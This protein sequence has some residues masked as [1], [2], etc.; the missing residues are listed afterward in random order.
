MMRWRG[1]IIINIMDQRPKRTRRRRNNKPAQNQVAIVQQPNNERRT[2]GRKAMGKYIAPANSLM[3]QAPGVSNAPRLRATRIKE[4]M[5]Q[6]PLTKD[7]SSFLKC[8]FAPPD[9]DATVLLGV[10]DEYQGRSLV[11]RHRLVQSVAYIA[12]STDYYYLLLPVP[13]YAYFVASVAAGT[14]ITSSTTFTGVPYS[15]SFPG[16]FGSSTTM[17]DN[18]N[19]FRFVSNHIEFVP[20]TNA[21]SWT[22]N[23][24]CFKAPINVF[25][26]QN[27]IA[28]AT[29]LYSVGG[30]Q[31]VNS[32]NVNQYTGPFNLGV[33]SGAYNNGS[34]F[35]FSPIFENAQ[36]IP[37]QWNASFG[38]WGILAVPTVPANA[39][40][41]TGFDNNFESVVIKVTGM[42]TNVSNTAIIKTWA[43]VE[44]QC[45]DSGVLYEYQNFSPC[46]PNALAL[47]RKIINE[48]PPGVAFTDNENFWR[49]VLEIIRRIS[50]AGAILPGPY[51]MASKGVNMLS[52]AISQLVL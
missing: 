46:D 50:G 42:G 6:Y 30:L 49:R 5:S 23:I 17:N 10:P 37:A 28:N 20:T 11:K 12:P 21:M 47:Y 4:L 33:Y 16:V 51:G 22:G 29:N 41:F 9:F 43:C 24:Q 14:P 19:K 35:D 40:G 44:Y 25:I 27:N 18:V 3:V 39:F 1:L 45:T 31:S 48:L 13:G 2:N 8:A 52:D 32:T 7:A 34:K 38:D 36:Q 15:D 26:R